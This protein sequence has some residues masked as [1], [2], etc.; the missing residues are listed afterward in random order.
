MILPITLL[1]LILWVLLGWC[2]SGAL[3]RIDAQE[4]HHSRNYCLSF[5]FWPLSMILWD[6]TQQEKDY[7]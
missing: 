6:A 7:D 4:L 3:M 2:W 1:S 5:I